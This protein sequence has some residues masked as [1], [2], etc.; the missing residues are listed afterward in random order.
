MTPCPR[1]AVPQL[2]NTLFCDECGQEMSVTPDP[3]AARERPVTLY[4][5]F[6]DTD[7]QITLPSRPEL[8]FG[9]GD[10]QAG[11][12]PDVDLNTLGGKE[13]GVSRRHA[14]LNHRREELY[15]EDLDSMN[16]TFVNGKRL[17]AYR[18]TLIQ[19]GDTIRLG[20]LRITFRFE[21]A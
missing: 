2:P 21:R 7:Q 6:L 16:G 18:R 5:K 17:P 10:R 14:R 3:L 1:C 8:I 11:N 20:L 13:G 15:L 9:R 19:P 12:N 4:C